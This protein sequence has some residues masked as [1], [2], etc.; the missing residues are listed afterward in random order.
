MSDSQV[1]LTL[2]LCI[3][4]YLIL[5]QYPR[6]EEDIRSHIEQE[7][8]RSSDLLLAIYHLERSKLIKSV[9]FKWIITKAGRSF[10]EEHQ[11]AV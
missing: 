3:L 1:P 6:F 8:F 5:S 11:E 7:G 4:Q 10:Y 9:K 2:K